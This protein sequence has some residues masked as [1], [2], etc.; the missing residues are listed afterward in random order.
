[1]THPTAHP[2]V[3]F[4]YVNRNFTR[5][6]FIRNQGAREGRKLLDQEVGGSNPL[7][8]TNLFT[9]LELSQLSI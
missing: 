1:M 4:W 6:Y 3:Y 5:K 7:A 9:N 2:R 8:P